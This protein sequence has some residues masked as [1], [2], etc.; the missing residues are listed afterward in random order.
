MTS[1]A[2]ASGKARKSKVARYQM[3]IDGRFVDVRKRE[4]VRGV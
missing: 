1:T 2:R 3:Y 4:D